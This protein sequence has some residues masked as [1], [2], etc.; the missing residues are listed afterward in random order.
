MASRLIVIK[1]YDRD[2]Y[3]ELKEACSYCI[4]RGGTGKNVDFKVDP[5]EYLTSRQHFFVDFYPPHIFVRDNKSTNGTLIQRG[6]DTIPVTGEQT[7]IYDGDL[8]IAGNTVFRL[9]YENEGQEMPFNTESPASFSSSLMGEKPVSASPADNPPAS[10]A[11]KPIY[12][13]PTENPGPVSSAYPAE[14]PVSAPP[15][16]PNAAEAAPEQ[17]KPISLKDYYSVVVP[18]I[19]LFHSA[20]VKCIACGELI[21]VEISPSELQAYGY[22]VFMCGNCSSGFSDERNLK[23]LDSYGILQELKEDG[24]GLVYLAR[25]KETGL[26]A[27][28]RAILP[29]LLGE[30]ILYLKREISVMQSVSHPNLARMYENVVH[31]DRAYLIYEYMPEGDLNNYLKTTSGGSLSWNDACSVV[32]DV[33]SGLRHCHEMGIV[34]GDIKPANILF[35]KDPRGN[36]TARLG[37]LGLAWICDNMGLSG[38]SSGHREAQPFKAPELIENTRSLKPE[39][40]IYS[41]GAILYFLLSGGLPYSSRTDDVFRNSGV[42]FDAKAIPPQDKG[43]D[44]PDALARILKRATSREP[45]GRFHN[46]AEMLQVILEMRL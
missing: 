28:I 14:K 2:K 34:H 12:A 43:L 9:E 13:S 32:C 18:E 44:I 30:D 23:D 42:S 31:R 11:E 29:R 3:L 17:H 7:E 37:E 15:V 8:I 35:K 1:G 16:S 38:F 40:D 26:L 20:Q 4:G 19:Q 21:T 6:N 46:A 24:I 22:P 45:E 41:M 5:C 25:H 33:L 36:P 27:E 39:A 10:S